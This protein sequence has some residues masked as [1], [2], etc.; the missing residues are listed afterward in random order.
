MENQNENII[1]EPE[2]KEGYTP[3]PMWQV[4]LARI[5]LV[6]FILLVIMYYIN[7]ARGGI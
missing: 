6:L 2:E 4:W 1:P 3:R 7:I 5:G